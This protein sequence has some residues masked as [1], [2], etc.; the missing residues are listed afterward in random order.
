MAFS[1]RDCRISKGDH[2]YHMKRASI[3]ALSLILFALALTGCRHLQPIALPEE[4]GAAPVEGPTWSVLE[5]GDGNDW[6]ALFNTGQEALDWRLRAIDSATRSIDLQ[7]F[8]WSP[9]ETGLRILDRLI[10]AADRDIKIRV[11]IDDTFTIHEDAILFD[12]GAHPNIEMRIYNPFSQRYDSFV[13]RQLLNLGEFSRVDHRMHNKIM[14]VDNRVAIIGGRNL[15]DEY[16]GQHE[17]HNFRDLEALAA[18]NIVPQITD[19]FDD[20]WNSGWAFP[21]EAIL[22]APPEE[23]N[24]DAFRAYLDESLPEASRE[25]PEVRAKK[26]RELAASGITGQAVLL[27]DEPAS[28]DPAHA[29]D[30]PDQLATELIG[31]LN[32]ASEEII[33]VSAYLIP[34]AELE[35]MI[36]SAEARG[37]E[38][39]ILTNSLQSNNHTAADSAYRHHVRRLLHHGADL[40]EVRAQAK[41]RFVYMEHPVEEKELGLHAK[42]ILIDYDQSFI[43]SANLDPRSLRLNTEIGLLIESTDL[44]RRLR[45]LIELDFH[46]RNAWQLIPAEDGS[47]QWVSDDTVLKTIP[48]DSKFQRIEDWFLRLL[49]IEGKM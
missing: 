21:V 2:G 46:P 3:H 44:N 42:L 14:L 10:E 36:E 9:D 32:Q 7:T 40:H 12:L 20:Y 31:Y 39:R 24:L 43:G 23:L 41:D 16:F 45:D 18:G 48:A 26:W 33:M 5:R 30:L 47:L 6:F 1:F 22:E 25:S 28:A 34:T 4:T 38:V 19:E 17:E 35:A 49:P 13:M 37:V 15:A 8:L 27:A 29:Q 11:L